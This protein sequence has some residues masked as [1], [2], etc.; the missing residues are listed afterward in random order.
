VPSLAALRLAPWS[1]SKIASARR[2][3]LEFHLRYVDRV[4]E[5]EVSAEAR[6][7]KAI[8]RVLEETIG[9]VPLAE[10]AAAAER[11]LLSDAE[12][13]RLRG[14]LPGCE[15]FVA[16]LGEFR[17]R[18][19]IHAEWVEHRLAVRAD[20][21]PTGFLARDGFFRGTW[22]AAFLYDAATLAV[23]D[24]KTGAARRA[25]HRDQLEGYA[26]LAVAHLEQVRR[27]W[28]GV[29]YVGDAADELDW[30]EPWEAD[31]VRAVAAPR[32]VAGIDAAAEGVADTREPRP[33]SFCAV[34]SYRS[35]CPAMR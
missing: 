21:R 11:G 8:H 12:R 2:C 19:H 7:G 18:R 3:P 31:D 22:D 27:L 9:R 30:G 14:L 28:L 29:H 23:I 17:A 24:H 20:L 6:V 26:T 15:R 35:L 34:C 1:P 5:P 33:G 32:L 10:A 13:E 25:E 16:R 4:P